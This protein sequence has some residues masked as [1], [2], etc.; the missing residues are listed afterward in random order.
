MSDMLTRY[1]ESKAPRV[2]EAKKIPD[3]AVDFVDTQ[4]V[5]QKGWTNDQKRGDPTTFTTTALGY[6]DVEVKNILIPD[7][8]QPIE[9]GVPLNRYGPKNK[10]SV[11]G[12]AGN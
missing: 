5:F 12:A 6:Y 7:G 10:Y 1:N 3:L 2:A 8:F 11:P 4:D 9:Q